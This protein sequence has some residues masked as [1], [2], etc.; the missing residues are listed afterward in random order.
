MGGRISNEHGFSLIEVIVAVAILAVGMLGVA[1]LL[2]TAMKS[3]KHSYQ[4]RAGDSA[5]LTDVEWL[6][7][8]LVDM[9]LTTDLLPKQALKGPYFFEWSVQPNQPTNG[10][11]KVELTV[12]WG[13]E[14]CDKD[15]QGKCRNQT[16]LTNYVMKSK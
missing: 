13:G 3:E 14:G 4:L 9:P 6:K 15:N 2:T 1:T 16:T 12:K 10:M 5:A 8:E 7:A 11:Y